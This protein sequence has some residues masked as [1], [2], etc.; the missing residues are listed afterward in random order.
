MQELGGKVA[1][2]DFQKYLFMLSQY[3]TKAPYNFVPYA[4]G[5]FSF[6]SYADKRA[7]AYYGLLQSTEDWVTSAANNVNYVESL[8]KPDQEIIRKVKRFADRHRGRALLQELYTR[9]P[10][11]AIKSTIAEEVLSAEDFQSVLNAI[12][13]PKSSELFTVGY[14]SLDIDSYTNRLISH[15]IRAVVDV[16]RNPMSMK[17]GFNK[18]QMRG[19]LGKLGIEYFHIPELGIATENRKNAKVTGFKKVFADY[20]ADLPNRTAQ[21]HEIMKIYAD[22][23]RIALTCFEKD[24]EACHRKRLT[25]N[26]PKFGFQPSV[27]HL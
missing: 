16:R 23:S 11:Y 26:L 10:Y 6:Q 25:D 17:Y 8:T 1:G 20:S 12:P 3:R 18:N 27:K 7:L 21:I 5:C 2:T 4:F 14:E 9:Y 22:Y 24:P 15:G 19:I 13:S